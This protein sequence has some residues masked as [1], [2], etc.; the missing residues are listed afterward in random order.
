[1]NQEEQIDRMHNIKKIEDRTDRIDNVKKY[2]RRQ[3]TRMTENDEIL[4]QKEQN[5]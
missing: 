4:K 3:P 1:M 5:R 2:R